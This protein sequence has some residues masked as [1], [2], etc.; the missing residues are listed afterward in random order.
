MSSFVA[1]FECVVIHMVA[2]HPKERIV[3][4]NKLTYVDNLS[5]LK[6]VM[7]LPNFRFVKLDICEQE[8]RYEKSSIN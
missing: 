3:C 4:L 7:N 6:D 5:M 1:C 8:T 2:E